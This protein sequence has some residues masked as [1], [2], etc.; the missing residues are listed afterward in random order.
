MPEFE[1]WQAATPNWEKWKCKYYKGLFSFLFSRKKN[2]NF[3]F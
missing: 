2:N 3:C 1:Q